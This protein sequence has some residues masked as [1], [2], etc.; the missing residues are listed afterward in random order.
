MAT[1]TLGEMSTILVTEIT[2]TNGLADPGPRS[3]ISTVPVEVA[4]ANDWHS[5]WQVYFAV[6]AIRTRCSVVGLLEN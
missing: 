5:S 4:L 6:L 3:Q 2:Q 1:P